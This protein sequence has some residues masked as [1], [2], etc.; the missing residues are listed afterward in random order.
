M[1][2]KFTVR[3]VLF[4]S[5]AA[6]LAV[7]AID[8]AGLIGENFFWGALEFVCGCA[9][10]AGLAALWLQDRYS[11]EDKVLAG[12]LL[13]CHIFS[14]WLWLPF[15]IGVCCRTAA[16][17]APDRQW[18]RRFLF[19][20]LTIVCGTGGYGVFY[21]G[22]SAPQPDIPLYQT[23]A[24]VIAAL[25]GPLLAARFVLAVPW[26]E[27]W[28]VFCRLLAGYAGV[29][30]ICSLYKLYFR[31]PYAWYVYAGLG[32]IGA[33]AAWGGWRKMSTPA[34]R[35]VLRLAWGAVLLL[36]MGH[37]VLE[38]WLDRYYFG[39]HSTQEYFV[40]R[41]QRLSPPILDAC[42]KYREKYGVWPDD[43]V[44]L[45]E[46]MKNADTGE[47]YITGCHTDSNGDFRIFLKRQRR[48]WVRV[49]CFRADGTEKWEYAAPD[50]PQRKPGD[51]RW[52]H[53]FPY[54]D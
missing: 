2:G 44:Q 14:F 13:F 39:F 43:P 10:G 18:F 30:L 46:F 32:L 16:E 28:R 5:A 35:K 9:A 7:A 1:S 29:L 20:I 34:N 48:I 45:K 23:A 53:A 19:A 4:L 42:R 27:A 51:R 11:R 33:G 25:A 6:G 3:P 26:R 31:A 47:V 36:T 52:K 50:H 17:P 15:F 54:T 38:C 12:I 40:S 49:Y 22:W 8:I 24:G 37:M 21:W 41:F